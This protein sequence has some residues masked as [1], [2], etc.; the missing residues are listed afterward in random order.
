[1]APTHAPVP[2]TASKPTTRTVFPPA[3]ELPELPS[4]GVER[5]PAYGTL[6]GECATPPGESADSPAV[7]ESADE[8]GYGCVDWFIYM[9]EPGQT[10]HP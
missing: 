5:S 8:L 9:S 10:G 6:P 2:G 3:T 7:R 4:W 1:M